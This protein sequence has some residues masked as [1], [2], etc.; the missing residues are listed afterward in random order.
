MRFNREIYFDSVRDSLFN[1]SM[2]QV[3]V[4][5]QNVILTIFE[6]RVYRGS[7][8]DLRHCA[9]PLATTAH[10]TGFEMAPIVEYGKGDGM[11]Y[12]VP[13]PETKQTYYGRGFVQLTW[14]DNYARA[15]RELQLTG[16]NDL[17]WH[18]DSA[19]KMP[20]AAAVMYQGMTGGWFR[21][22]DDGK[23]ETLARYFSNT[24]NDPYEAREIINGDKSK[25]PS[26]SGG[27]SIGNLIKG[28][29]EKFLAALEVSCAQI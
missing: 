29:H 28:Y 9:Y 21:T 3:Q 24:V 18:A 14:R 19:L 1:G 6:M 5:G 12:G 2:N 26:W 8:D 13:D 16:E 4:N 20:I 22:H 27:V 25:V 7:T 17:E 10:E 15:T 23:P 11:E